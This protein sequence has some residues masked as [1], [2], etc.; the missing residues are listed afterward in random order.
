MSTIATLIELGC[1]VRRRDRLGLTALH[2]ALAMERSPQIIASL[3][4]AGASAVDVG[5]SEASL[6]VAMGQGGAF[7]ID[8]VRSS[9]DRL[10]AFGRHP[11]IWA[12]IYGDA[13]FIEKALRS[14][15]SIVNVP[16]SVGWTALHHA[17]ARGNR[18]AVDQLLGGGAEPSIRDSMGRTP[19]MYA[20]I[21]GLGMSAISDADGF[22]SVRDRD[23]MNAIDLSLK[24]GTLG[25]VVDVW[26]RLTPEQEKQQL[27][28][29]RKLIEERAP[30]WDRDRIVEFL[31][32]RSRSGA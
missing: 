25:T 6:A 26:R 32:E 12:A 14:E 4:L 20:V 17:A 30:G 2:Y 22:W 19:A 24:F 11:L 21:S 29:S 1:D 9:A 3:S 5:L 27:P 28:K 15:G 31:E 18:R 23:G 7:K 13:P 16:D 8:G 10:D